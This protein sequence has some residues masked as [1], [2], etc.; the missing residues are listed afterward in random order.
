MDSCIQIRRHEEGWRNQTISSLSTLP[1]QLLAIF[2]IVILLLYLSSSNGDYKAQLERNVQ[3]SM[4]LL[5]LLLVFV[6]GFLLMNDYGGL[7]SQFFSRS[8]KLGSQTTNTICQSTATASFPWGVAV[9]V[10]VVLVLLS[11]QSSFQAKW[12][13]F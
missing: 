7:Y 11:Y 3:F 2:A 1:L 12:T 6:L 9:L 8:K 4:F 10:V 5:P 13:I